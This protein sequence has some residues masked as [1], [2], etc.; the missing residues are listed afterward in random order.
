MAAAATTTTTSPTS[1][2]NI[3]GPLIT[4]YVAPPICSQYAE[5][6]GPVGYAAQGCSSGNIVDTSS[7]WPPALV[8]APG[9]PYFGW[10][11]YSPGLI[12][13]SGYSSACTTTLEKS[14]SPP[15]FATSFSFQFP[16]IPGETAVGCCP[17]YVILTIHRSHKLTLCHIEALH[18]VAGAFKQATPP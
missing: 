12:C 15:S 5:G 7:C 1:T 17:T 10:G 8:S 2:R 4:T 13:P 11:F 6:N 14:G 18:V 9:Q 3:L 16:L